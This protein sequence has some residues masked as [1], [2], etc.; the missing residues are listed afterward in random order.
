MLANLII[1]AIRHTPADGTVE[2][3]A[4]RSHGGVELT[5]T[6]GCGG[7]PEDDRARVF[8]V[9]WRGSS[10]R[11]RPDGPAQTSTS[12]ARAPGWAW[13]SSRASSRRTA[14]RWA[15]RTS[16]PA[17]GCRFLVRLLTGS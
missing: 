6:D 15:S 7:I 12:D 2:S 10:A 4:A 8:D 11:A 17:A 14:A 3:S 1:N 13:P 9:A 16:T 5:V